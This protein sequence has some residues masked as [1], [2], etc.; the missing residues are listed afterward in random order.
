MLKQV[1]KLLAT[2]LRRVKQRVRS[3]AVQFVQ[4]F[5]RNLKVG[6]DCVVSVAFLSHLNHL[7][8]EKQTNKLK[9]AAKKMTFVLNP[10]RNKTLNKILPTEP[11]CLHVSSRH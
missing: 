7:L 10:N 8:T 1:V 6:Y 9:D 4:L 3:N 2:V 11:I 5:L